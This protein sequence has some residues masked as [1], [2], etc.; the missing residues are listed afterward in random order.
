M[1]NNYF[2]LVFTTS[3]LLVTGPAAVAECTIDNDR[4]KGT[5]FPSSTKKELEESILNE[6]N[7]E[8]CRERGEEGRGK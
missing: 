5:I 6:K 3:T 1:D 7:D 4:K 8:N 2:Y